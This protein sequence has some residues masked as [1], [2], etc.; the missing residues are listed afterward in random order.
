M[1]AFGDEIVNAIQ[2]QFDTPLVDKLEIRVVVDSFYDRFPPKLEHP[3]VKI[4][5]TGR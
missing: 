3:S 4:E 5:Q 1:A 2:T